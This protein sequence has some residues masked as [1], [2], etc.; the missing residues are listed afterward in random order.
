LTIEVTLTAGKEFIVDKRAK[1]Y[2]QISMLCNQLDSLKMGIELSQ[3]LAKL[4]YK[5]K[6]DDS[7]FHTGPGSDSED[8]EVLEL[9]LIGPDF[10]GDDDKTDDY[11]RRGRNYNYS[12]EGK[13]NIVAFQVL[14]GDIFATLKIPLYKSMPLEQFKKKYCQTSKDAAQRQPDDKMK[15]RDHRD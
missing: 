15:Q 6:Y 7:H 4:G 9:S 10:S 13:S 14:E 5:L 2:L 11:N 1:T 8:E 3:S 12:H